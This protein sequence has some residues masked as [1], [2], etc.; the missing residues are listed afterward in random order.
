[1]DKIYSEEEIDEIFRK[2]DVDK[3]G[4]ISFSEYFA[5]AINR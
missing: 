3:N 4:V 5:A 1:M 2:V